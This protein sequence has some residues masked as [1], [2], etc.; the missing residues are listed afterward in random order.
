[1]DTLSQPD[2]E[3]A[4]KLS[5]IEQSYRTKAKQATSDF[6]IACY[7]QV[8]IEIKKANWRHFDECPVCQASESSEAA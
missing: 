6:L 3:V 4:Q 2:C 8:A 7:W 1:M 5:T